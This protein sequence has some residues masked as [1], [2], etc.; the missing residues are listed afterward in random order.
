MVDLAQRYGIEAAVRPIDYAFPKSLSDCKSSGEIVLN[1]ES[2][3]N[4]VELLSIESVRR[5]NI[6][7]E[8][9]PK[10]LELLARSKRLN[11]VA[12]DEGANLGREDQ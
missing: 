9:S 2:Q 6:S 12:F 10:F 8:V 5:V 7:G 1:G 4:I 3:A 11:R